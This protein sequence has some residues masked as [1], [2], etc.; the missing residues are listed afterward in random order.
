MKAAPIP[1]N[2]R[3]AAPPLLTLALLSHFPAH[4]SAGSF[5]SNDDPRLTPARVMTLQQDGFTQVVIDGY[6]HK[7]TVEAF[8]AKVTN[9]GGDYGI[10]YFNSS[11][12]DLSAAEE[13][14]RLIRAKGYATQI[15]K[16]TPDQSQIGRGVCESACPIAF[17]G[18]KFRLLDSDTGQLGI[19]RFYLAQQ[20]RWAADTKVLFTA[21]RDLRAYLDEMGIDP[22]FLEVMM[23]T[24]ADRILP[25]GKLSSYTWKLGTGSEYSFWQTTAA[26]AL[27]GIGE[28]STGA[29]TLTFTCDASAVHAQARFKPWFPATALLNYETHSFTVNSAKFPVEAVKASFDKQTGYIAFDATVPRGALMKLTSADR[30]GYS[31]SYDN[32]PGEY[33]RSLGLEDGGK[34]LLELE[35]HCVEQ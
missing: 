15:G 22:E 4:A 30:V 31:L 25:I 29:M 18:G 24:P 10:V 23:K 11:G 28:N 32:Q 9:Q 20:G 13:L 19:H 26:G 21:E 27:Q 14:G 7:P 16:L 6:I 34:A 1:R 3:V 33:N 17:V 8:R 35:A 5:L 2:W 12:G